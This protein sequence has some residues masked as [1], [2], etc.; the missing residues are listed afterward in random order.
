MLRILTDYLRSSSGSVR[1][2]GVDV[3]EHAA[4]N[5][6]GY[7]PEDA[8]LYDWMR[9]AEFLQFMAPTKP[10]DPPPRRRPIFRKA[11]H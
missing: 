8:P 3:A 9:I 11:N 1:I 6:P 2:G 4:R 10:G 5:Y 7:V